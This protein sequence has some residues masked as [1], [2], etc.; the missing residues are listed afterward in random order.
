MR[1]F[2]SLYLQVLFAIVAGALLGHFQ[3]EFATSLKPLGDA[4]IKFIK[5]L[6]APL[7]FTTIVAGIGNVGD[8]R[9]VGRV[10]L[11]ALFYFEA[12]TTVALLLGLLVVNLVQPG[13]GLHANPATLDASSVQNYTATAKHLT[14]VEFLLGIIPDTFVGAFAS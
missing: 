12:V 3:P 14:V 2:R 11:K 10:G 13:A 7:I 4:F 1:L 5:A 6:I 8:L 9:K